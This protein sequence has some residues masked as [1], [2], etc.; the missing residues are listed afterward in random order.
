MSTLNFNLEEIKS[1]CRSAGFSNITTLGD[2]PFCVYLRNGTA[3]N[4]LITVMF[5]TIVSKTDK[6]RD[7]VNPYVTDGETT[8]YFDS[9]T[10]LVDIL[11][12]LKPMDIIDTAEKKVS[13]KIIKW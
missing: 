10:K 6:Y 12:R 1:H 2:T 9:Y 4:K 3:T 5:R 13:K 11:N 8:V 7:I